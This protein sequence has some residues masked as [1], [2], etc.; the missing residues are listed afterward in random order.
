[1][2]YDPTENTLLSRNEETCGQTL[3]ENILKS[4]IFVTTYPYLI[5]TPD[6]NPLN[7]ELNPIC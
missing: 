5:E 3:G 6:I 4:N 1:M 7:P 2:I